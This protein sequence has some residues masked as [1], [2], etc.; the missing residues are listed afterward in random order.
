MFHSHSRVTNVRNQRYQYPKMSDVLCARISIVRVV[1]IPVID[2]IFHRRQVIGRIWTIISRARVPE[3]LPIDMITSTITCSSTVRELKFNA[4]VMVRVLRARVP[5][6]SSQ[7]L[8]TMQLKYMLH[9][10]AF[11]PK[12]NGCPFDLFKWILLIETLPIWPK[13]KCFFPESSI[14]NDSI[15]CW[16]SSIFLCSFLAV[17]GKCNEDPTWKEFV[18]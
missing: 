8:L 16:F 7:G 11:S 9:I 4:N 13:F 14:D 6:S 2:R 5:K 12:R 10:T 18:D 3:Y 17:F 15:Y 1:S